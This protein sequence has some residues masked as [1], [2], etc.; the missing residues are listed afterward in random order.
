[1]LA[2][3]VALSYMPFSSC[4]KAYI[5][6][7][8]MTKRLVMAIEP[9]NPDLAPFGADKTES[10]VFNISSGV[11]VV[12]AQSLATVAVEQLASAGTILATNGEELNIVYALSTVHLVGQ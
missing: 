4:C 1:M 2:E 12:E 10:A 9:T 7:C 6:D 5:S 8:V 11:T 3:E